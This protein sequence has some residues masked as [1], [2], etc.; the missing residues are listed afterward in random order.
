MFVL[1][2]YDFEQIYNIDWTVNSCFLLNPTFYPAPAVWA[3]PWGQQ[4]RFTLANHEA[5]QTGLSQKSDP[6]RQPRL[7]LHHLAAGCLAVCKYQRRKW[8]QSGDA[9]GGPS[10]GSTPGGYWIQNGS[11]W[12]VTVC[13]VC[14]WLMGSAV[15]YSR[16]ETAQTSVWRLIQLQPEIPKQNQETN[17]LCSCCLATA[18]LDV[19]RQWKCCITE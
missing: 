7:H 11:Q 10:L 13:T 19:E 16:P 4:T 1:Y 15:C 9:V 8:C 14:D 12:L 2:R 17:V 18:F 5:V 3:R 6:N